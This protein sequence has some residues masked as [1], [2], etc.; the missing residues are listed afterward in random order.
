MSTE[1]QEQIQNA[2]GE[3]MT[4]R[5]A[6]LG[7]DRP[8]AEPI[9]AR[10]E[11]SD[12]VPVQCACG[13][14]YRANIVLTGDKP[15]TWPGQC[16]RCRTRREEAARA[17]DD[18]AATR[19][20]ERAVSDLRSRL[21]ALAI[22]PKYATVTLDTFEHHGSAEDKAVQRR[23]LTWSR[24]FLGLWPEVP[25][26]TVF[27]GGFGTGKGHVAWALA[28]AVVEQLGGTARF[29]KL[30]ALVRELRDTW[31][32]DSGLTYQ[33]VLRSFTEPDLLVIDEASRHAFY[34]DQVHQHL[35]D[36]I[37]TRIDEERPTIVTT[38]EDD[39]GLAMVLRGA[40]VSRLEY[41]GGIVPFGTASW[42]SRPQPH[43]QEPPPAA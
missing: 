38:N 19:A 34:G 16:E 39:A 20:R 11:V 40:L 28:R 31:R 3:R 29:V 27:Q 25:A 10:L 22:P 18:A 9:A 2:L 36:V 43:H 24:R 5:R 13:E 21:E 12:G 35:Y 14:T 15:V 33:R 8:A 7:L 41:E 23:M 42:R 32:R 30:P 26:F 6:Q 17:R 1:D 4:I 37:D